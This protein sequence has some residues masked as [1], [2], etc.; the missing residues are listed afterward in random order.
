[1]TYRVVLSPQ[2]RRY[3]STVDP[4]MAARLNHVFEAL[5]SDWRPFA[6]VPLKGELDGFWRIRVGHLRIIYQVNEPMEEVRITRIA[7][8]GD[9]Y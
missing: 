3:Y 5:E 1:V 9:V 2:A 4:K 8:R 7:P 6:A